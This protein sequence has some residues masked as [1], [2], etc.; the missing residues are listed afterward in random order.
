MN[1]ALHF[2]SA[3]FL[4]IGAAAAQPS[5]TPSSFVAML[6]TYQGNGCDGVKRMGN[7]SN[8]LGRRPDF[9]LD[10][11]ASDSWQSMQGDA[12]WASKCWSHQPIEVVFS[13]P[14]LMN[15]H[16]TLAEGASG[17]FDDQFRQL[18]ET[19][20]KNGFA[21]SVIRLGWEFNGGWYPWAAKK[22]PENWV[23]Y[24]RRIV[25]TMKSVP[26]AA[27]LFDWCVAQGYQQIPAPNV[28]PGDEYVDVIGYDF[29]NQIWLKQQPTPEERWHQLVT[30][31]YGLN[32]LN[33]FATRHDKPISIPEW[34]TGTRP[35][36]HGGDDDDYFVNNM[37][38]WIR[39]HN[40]AYH[41]YW[42]YKAK[43]Y[44]G[45]LSDGRRPKSAMA[46]IKAFRSFPTSQ[47]RTQ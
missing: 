47:E 36:G 20:I 37:A 34:A 19:L 6:G 31:A 17:K 18:A 9:V 11:I 7:F 5:S 16:G 40:V 10:F 8:W 25:T 28:Y 45:K 22:D 14:M 27:F 44:D 3:V 39:Q 2:F 41:A 15:D 29:Y 23:K 13:V 43:D 24:W 1:R 42:D 38:E 4:C 46:F 35:D 26:G 33:D 12:N 32:W 30:Q 21:H